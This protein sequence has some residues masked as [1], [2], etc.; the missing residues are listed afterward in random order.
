LN[1]F[2]N[3]N[4]TSNATVRLLWADNSGKPCAGCS[5][6]LEPYNDIFGVFPGPVG[7]AF[8]GNHTSLW[9]QIPQPG[10]SVGASGISSFWFEVTEG[11]KTWVEDQDG[12]GFPL[13]TDVVL[14]DSSCVH[15]AKNGT[16]TGHIDVA[17]RLFL[18]RF[19]PLWWG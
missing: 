1:Q 2:W 11:G 19:M 8:A 14:S 5:V 15:T 17:V 3:L 6:Q 4:D 13:Q 7:I 16:R 9:F 10:L 18:S 12:A